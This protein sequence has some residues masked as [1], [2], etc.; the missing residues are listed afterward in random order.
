[1]MFWNDDERPDDVR[2]PDDIVDILFGID[3]RQI[4]VD[5]AYILAAEL[6]DA[7][8][9]IADEPG[10]GI[11]TVHV[12]GSQNGWERPEH[13]TESCLYVSRRTKLTI[14]APKHRVAE[15]LDRLPGT[16][17]DLAGHGLCVG[18][19]KIKP[20][21]TDGTLFARYVALDLAETDDESAFLDA[22]AQ[23]LSALEIRVRKAL[24]GKTHPLSTPEGPIRTRSL[25]LAGLNPQES[26][27][28]QQHGL[29][30]HALLGCGIFIPHKGI[31]SV[32]KAEG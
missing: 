15:L 3:C 12:A 10:I 13:G 11:H 31:D 24:C 27:R 21:S 28:L 26:I 25:M 19:G 7:L 9:W 23:G 29:G 5:H 14:R 16:R 8:P 20:L 4:P 30:R 2:A 18:A 17:L 22:A 32:K 6:Q 1:M